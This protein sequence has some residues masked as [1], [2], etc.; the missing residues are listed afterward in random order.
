VN[1]FN[2]IV[3]GWVLCA[4]LLPAGGVSAGPEDVKGSASATIKQTSERMLA[5]LERQRP[6]LE[7]NPSRIY[8]LV[9]RILVPHFDFK[10]ITRA[11]VGRKH[12]KQATPAERR[13][14]IRAFQ[15]LLIRTY[16]KALLNYSGQKIRYLSEK[17][18]RRSSVMVF[19]EVPE[20]GA[21]PV[22]VNYKVHKK[23]GKW[24]IYDVKIDNVSLVSNYRSSFRSQIGRDKNGIRRLINRIRE[25]NA[26]GKR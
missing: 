14:L 26:K 20:P 11:A 9:N 8:G 3:I 15:D 12:W 21:D 4:G 6:A 1:R 7:R 13:D 22:P 17:P 2:R 25:M 16:A 19:T 5:A 23:G 10:R 24:K 18:G